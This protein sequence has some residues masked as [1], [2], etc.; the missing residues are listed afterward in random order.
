MPRSTLKCYVAALL[1]FVALAS[2]A[3]AIAATPALDGTRSP[4]AVLATG[5]AHVVVALFSFPGCPYCEVVRRNYLRHLESEIPGVRVVEY[6]IGDERTFADTSVAA[7]AKANPHT[8]TEATR[9]PPSARAEATVKHVTPSAKDADHAPS[10]A[11]LARSFGIRVAPTVV[12]LANGG[13]E[14]AE[15]LVG[16]NSPDFYGAYLDRRI[17]SALE[18]AQEQ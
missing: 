10:P 17:A 12:F 11:A 5:G 4:Q 9:I 14:V 16:Y 7:D 1:A 15:R 13:G 8:K 18:R 6:G 3:L 2:S